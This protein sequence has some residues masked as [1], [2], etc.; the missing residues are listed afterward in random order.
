MTALATAKHVVVLAG[1]GISVSCGIPD[2]RSKNGI[3]D[4]VAGMDL[5]LLDGDPQSLFDLEYFLDDPEPFYRFAHKLYP[6]DVRPS[7]TH[8]F[9]ARLLV[10]LPQ[11]LPRREAHGACQLHFATVVFYRAGGSAAVDLRCPPVPVALQ[12]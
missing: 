9:L 10:L 3:Y 1:A 7:P 6:R 5:G 2:F 4:L 11:L 8:H 12:Q